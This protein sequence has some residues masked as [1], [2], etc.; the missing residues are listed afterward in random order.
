MYNTFDNK[1]ELFHTAIDLDSRI[2]AELFEGCLA[3]DTA[4]VGVDRLLRKGVTMFT[5]H[6]SGGV[7]F[8][9]QEPL[10]GPDTSEDTRQYVAKKREA[11]ELAL[12]DRFDR[13]IEAGE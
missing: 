13:V 11:I 3:A 9:I 4:R 8:V 1:E 6:A 10:T 12:R 2:G 7:C 5:D